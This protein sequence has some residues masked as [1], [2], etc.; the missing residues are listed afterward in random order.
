MT[1]TV[2]KAGRV[3]AVLGGLAYLG[4]DA[5]SLLGGNLQLPTFIVIE[6]LVYAAAYLAGAA[7][8]SDPRVR[9][10]VALIAAFNAGRVSRSIVTAVGTIGELAIAHLPLLLGLLALAIVSGAASLRKDK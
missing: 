4:F 3:L 7:F 6:N 5:Y 9:L 10:A 8:Y 1:A 2:V